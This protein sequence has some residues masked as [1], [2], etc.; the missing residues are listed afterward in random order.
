MWRWDDVHR[1]AAQ[2]TLS[3]SFP[4]M[5]ESLDPP[6]VQV[7]GDH[8][9]LQVSGF[10]VAQDTTYRLTN[11]SV[12]R[13]VIDF[14]APEEASWIIPGGASAI[15][16]SPHYSDQLEDWRVSRRVPMHIEPES[17]RAAAL[18]TLTLD[19]A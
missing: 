5:A 19:P 17:A 16:G 2:H 12:Y 1:T 3:A 13:Q 8:D 14:A 9:T 15:P 7:G 11:L 6:P 4:G 10:R 18:T